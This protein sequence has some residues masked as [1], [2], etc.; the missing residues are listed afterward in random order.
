M[1]P[2]PIWF[3]ASQIQT[4]AVG[5]LHIIRLMERGNVH[6]SPGSFVL[7]GALQ[8]QQREEKG[9]KVTGDCSD[10]CALCLCPRSPRA[11]PPVL[12][13]GPRNTATLPIKCFL[14]LLVSLASKGDASPAA[15][16]MRAASKSGGG[17]SAGKRQIVSCYHPGNGSARWF[18]ETKPRIICCQGDAACA[19]CSPPETG[20]RS[21][22]QHGRAK[23]TQRDR[24]DG[25]EGTRTPSSHCPARVKVKQIPFSD[26]RLLCQVI[27]PAR[28]IY[29][30]DT[31]LVIFKPFSLTPWKLLL[32]TAKF[33]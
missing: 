6:L 4:F 20:Q 24:R 15:P 26:W 28:G 32:S 30:H 5:F 12:A 33:K 1:L 11:S 17:L 8:N 9:R 21:Q 25:P 14:Q 31:E 19:S 2:L 3:F 22:G 7:F 23:G 18:S 27:W 13:L 10:T 16:S 29:F